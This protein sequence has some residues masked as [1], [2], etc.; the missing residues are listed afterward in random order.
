[1]NRPRESLLNLFDPL[2]SSVSQRNGGD[3]SVELDDYDSEK[4]NN[5]PLGDVT[6]VSFFNG[7]LKP[8]ACLQPVPLKCRLIDV[9][10]VTVDN[11]LLMNEVLEEIREDEESEDEDSTVILG[12]VGKT[13]KAPSSVNIVA[14]P[15][16]NPRTPFAELRM[17]REITPV[18]HKRLL[19]RQKQYTHPAAASDSVTQPQSSLSSLVD[20]VTSAGIS[21]AAS[22]PTFPSPD[23]PDF[24]TSPF[25]NVLEASPTNIPLPSSPIDMNELDVPTPRPRQLPPPI[26]D[27]DRQSLDL[28]ASFQLQFDLAESSFDLLTDKISF[29]GSRS[30]DFDITSG[31]EEETT[32]VITC[33]G[34]EDVVNVA[35]NIPLPSEDSPQTRYP[36]SATHVQPLNDTDSP[37]LVVTAKTYTPTHAVVPENSPQCDDAHVIFPSTGDPPMTPAP[38]KNLH[39][40]VPPPIHALRIVKRTKTVAAAIAP[41][42][43]R[44]LSTRPPAHTE[45]KL[46]PPVQSDTPT[47]AKA[48]ESERHAPVAAPPKSGSATRGWRTWTHAKEQQT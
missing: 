35:A 38:S 11:T 9:G 10:D 47:S 18:A 7:A 13:P 32:G 24:I 40:V 16:L 6:M 22:K 21:F 48:S 14:T 15:R 45:R 39:P 31:D 5:M 30:H 37:L 2:F 34:G 27:H 4:E 23:I 26:C 28:H 19:M 36:Y 29:L 3:S 17:E 41:P 46:S 44:R 42:P 43:D 8:E 1:M 25:R 20:A 12:Q 33:S